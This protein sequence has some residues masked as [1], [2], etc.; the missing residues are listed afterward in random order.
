MMLNLAVAALEHLR[1]RKQNMF[2]L[3]KIYKKIL[4][5]VFWGFYIG[6]FYQTELSHPNWILGENGSESCIIFCF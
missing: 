2:S 5:N 3:K 1:I 6:V 4:L